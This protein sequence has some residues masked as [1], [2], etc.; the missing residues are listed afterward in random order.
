MEFKKNTVIRIKTTGSKNQYCL[1][2]NRYSIK[3]SSEK[4][5]YL[6]YDSQNVMECGGGDGVIDNNG[7]ANPSWSKVSELEEVYDE[8]IKS[9][10]NKRC[11]KCME[12]FK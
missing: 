4:C 11:P 3:D 6:I 1:G 7:C 10:E 8:E 12:I 2:F 9:L 5:N